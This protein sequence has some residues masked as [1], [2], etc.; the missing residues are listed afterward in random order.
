MTPDQFLQKVKQI[1]WDYMSD[2]EVMHSMLD[3][4][5]EELLIDLGYGEAVEYVRRLER[6]YA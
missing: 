1:A 2:A 4:A 6:W 3:E 5:I